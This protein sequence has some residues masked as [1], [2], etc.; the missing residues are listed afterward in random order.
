MSPT[1]ASS[2]HPPTA[3]LDQSC[4]SAAALELSTE[5]P[6]LWAK[7][8]TRTRD[9]VCMYRNEVAQKSK[10]NATTV[11]VANHPRGSI[12]KPDRTESRIKDICV[13][14][15]SMQKETPACHQMV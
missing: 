7:Q 9:D 6:K 15:G 2:G 14:I 13:E 3:K 12:I 11:Q 5:I 1:G 4:G 10:E 8:P